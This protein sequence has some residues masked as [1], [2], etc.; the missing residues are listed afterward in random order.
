MTSA[1][2]GLYCETGKILWTFFHD[3]VES[4]QI[5]NLL[6][7]RKVNDSTIIKQMIAKLCFMICSSS[8]NQHGA[9]RFVSSTV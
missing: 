3:I 6:Q 4:T 2:V 5:M 8:Y 1:L 9:V 7:K